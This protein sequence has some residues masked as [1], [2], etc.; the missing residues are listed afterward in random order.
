MLK[1]WP[2]S[3]FPLLLI[4]CSTIA[5]SQSGTSS[6]QGIVTDSSGAVVPNAN[7]AL[8]NTATSVSMRATSDTAGSYSFPSVPPGIY[9]IEVTKEGFAPYKLDGFRVIVGQHAS[10]NVTLGVASSVATVV[11]NANGL[12]NLLDTESN[13]LGTV[14]GPQ[15]V[16]QLPLNGRNY[17][18]LGLLSGAATQPAGAAAGSVNQTGHPQLAIQVAGNE[19]DYTMYVVNGL[20]TVASRAGNT[21][22]NLSMGAIDQFEVHY[23]FFMPD[24]GPNPGIVDVVTKSG[25]NHIHGE[26]YEYLRTNQMQARDYFAITSAGVPIAPGKYHQD[27]FGFDFGGPI[28]RDKLFYLETTKGIAK[29]SRS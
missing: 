17:L 6:V 18:Q 1:R 26:A 22:L 9:S 21:S 2:V 14:I 5:L 7:V 11:V 10:S 24:M 8:T 20:E 28:F 29:T 16:S 4:V 12:T 15:A 13:D 19:P 27:Q 23:G 3:L 25:T